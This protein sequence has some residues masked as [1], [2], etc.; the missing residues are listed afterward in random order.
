LNRNQFTEA[1]QDLGC[2]PKS[3]RE[4]RGWQ[5]LGL[6]EDARAIYLAMKQQNRSVFGEACDVE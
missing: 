3:K 4:G 6:R 2:H 1:L 5:G